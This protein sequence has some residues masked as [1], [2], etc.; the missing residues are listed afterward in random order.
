MRTAACILS[1]SSLASI[2]IAIHHNIGCPD[3]ILMHVCMYMP[4][5]LCTYNTYTSPQERGNNS[6]STVLAVAVLGSW[7]TVRIQDDTPN[8][9]CKLSWRRYPF[10]LFELPSSSILLPLLPAR[11]LDLARSPTL[12]AMSSIMCRSYFVR[13]AC[14]T[15]CVSSTND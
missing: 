4:L 13:C 15:T 9:S 5:R 11:W 8:L 2:L 10:H 12:S 1:Y 3:I 14:D 6:D 7:W